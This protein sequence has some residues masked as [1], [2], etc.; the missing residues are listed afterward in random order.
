[1]VNTIDMTMT[2]PTLISILLML[3]LSVW[4]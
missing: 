4:L 2:R 1:M 3:S